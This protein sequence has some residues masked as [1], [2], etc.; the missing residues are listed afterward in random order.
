MGAIVGSAPWGAVIEGTWLEERERLVESTRLDWCFGW[1][2]P[3]VTNS[4]LFRTNTSI[5]VH[6][7]NSLPLCFVV[8]EDVLC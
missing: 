4:C 5:A 7:V 1:F 3:L 2:S 8:E 6:S